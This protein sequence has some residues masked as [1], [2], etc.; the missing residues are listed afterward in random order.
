MRTMTC[1]GQRRV[2]RS[3][4]WRQS[5]GAAGARGRAVRH[6]AT[7][8]SS[9]ATP[10]AGRGSVRRAPAP[11]RRAVPRAP[12]RAEP[13]RPRPPGAP[14]RRRGES[15]SPGPISAT[16]TLT[17][18]ALRGR[19]VEL[20][21]QGE[22]ELRVDVVRRGARARPR[23]T[24]DRP[25]AAPPAAG[26]APGGSGQRP[27]RDRARRCRQARIHAGSRARPRSG[28]GP[29]RG[30]A[31]ARP[32]R[33]PPARRGSPARSRAACQPTP[34]SLR[35]ALPYPT[36]STRAGP[37]RPG[38]AVTG[39]PPATFRD[40]QRASSS[41]TF[42]SGASSWIRSAIWPRAWVEQER[43]GS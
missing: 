26:S 27:H 8:R 43:H 11:R 20:E 7:G 6:A 10:P 1:S 17:T 9:C 12:P 2:R 37:R 16:P 35:S 15:A 13:R 30:S 3:R 34:S 38:A 32:G 19:P 41:S 18:T 28:R 31:G 22:Q 40:R 5:P 29:A 42:P 25:R 4:S 36:T 21:G 33:L 39:R 14:P 23:G 24:R